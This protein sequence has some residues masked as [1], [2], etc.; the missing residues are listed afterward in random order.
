MRRRTW[1]SRAR[2]WRVLV[3]IEASGR[4]ADPQS[5]G[6]LSLTFTLRQRWPAGPEHK[7]NRMKKKIVTP[8]PS[9]FRPDPF[10]P[11]LSTP[12]TIGDLLIWVA[13][14]AAFA[15]DG[16][17]HQN[18]LHPLPLK[19]ESARYIATYV[20]TVFRPR[21]LVSGSP[22]VEILE[23]Y[24]ITTNRSEFEIEQTTLYELAE[25]LKANLKTKADTKTDTKK[26]TEK[27]LPTNPDAVRLINELNSG[28]LEH[29]Q[30]LEK[31]REITESSGNNPQSIARQVRRYFDNY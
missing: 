19:S 26:K 24:Q 4:L 14:A 18:H 21:T 7:V 8:P 27:K 25:F 22:L 12:H 31:A 6:G 29:G 3:R 16:P 9:Y 11:H 13:H 20:A 30:I 5:S 23:D 15:N 17:L 28:K 2:L 1:Q 10:D